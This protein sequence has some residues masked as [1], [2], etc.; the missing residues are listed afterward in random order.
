LPGSFFQ[1]SEGWSDVV[2]QFSDI[3]FPFQESHLSLYNCTCCVSVAS[4]SVFRSHSVAYRAHI[5]CISSHS[6]AP[7]SHFSH[8]LGH[9]SATFFSAAFSCFGFSVS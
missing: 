3:G 1:T 8:H 7:R 5:G 9:S 4:W 6:V 2:L